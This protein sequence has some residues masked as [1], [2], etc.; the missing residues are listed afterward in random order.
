MPSLETLDDGQRALLQLLLKQGKSYDDLAA[1]LKTDATGVRR[2]AHDAV[3][4]LGPVT[5]G[6]GR[7]RRTE[8]ADYLLGQQTA[9]QRAATREFL[10]G[11]AAG[12]TWARTAAGALRPM[13]PEGLPEVPA[14]PEEMEQA[15]DALD[16]RT[17]RQQEVSRSNR[18]GGM[19][20]FAGLGLVL[21]IGLLWALGAFDSSDKPSTAGGATSTATTETPR[22]YETLQ[23]AGMKPPKGGTPRA[24][25]VAAIV[26][27]VGTED[28]SLA[29]RGNNVPASPSAGSAY[30]VWLYSSPSSQ[31]FLGF[32]P[33]V[34]K[35]R[36]VEQAFELP[37]DTA[38]YKQVLLTRETVRDPKRP[39]AIVLRGPLQIVPPE[40]RGQ[41][42]T[43]TPPQATTPSG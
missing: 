17:A 34:G 22:R 4:A 39:G 18:A 13:A 38:N 33:L 28:L 2:R 7:D 30:A 35:N 20:L 42:T 14:E 27:T 19:L 31:L 5:A 40:A 25:G 1:L 36:V 23:L 8:I 9:S 37:K 29:I 41:G 11:S 24:N 12:R 32:T 3:E 15:F 16:R 6:I 21:A 10:E 26:R 43:T